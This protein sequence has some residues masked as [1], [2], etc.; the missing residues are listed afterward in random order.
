MGFSEVVGAGQIA[1]G[2]VKGDSSGGVRSRGGVKQG[3]EIGTGRDDGTGMRVGSTKYQLN[4]I[5]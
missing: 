1:L 2:G 4:I 5:E 3:G